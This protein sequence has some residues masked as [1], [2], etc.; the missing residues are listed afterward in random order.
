MKSPNS[1]DLVFK[2]LKRRKKKALIAY[3]AGGYP[4]WNFQR[5]LIKALDESGVDILE[6]GVPFSDPIADG[7]TIQFA[8][9]K[10]LSY[11]TTLQRI[12]AWAKSIRN[13]VKMPF[14]IMSYMNPILN[15]GLK[16]FA[17]DAADSGISGVIVPDLIPEEGEDIKKSLESEG[18]YLIFLVAPTTPKSRQK[19]IAHKTK[20]FLYAVS[21][22]GVTGARKKLPLETKIWLKNLSRLTTKPVCVGFGISGPKQ[23]KML[24][25]SVDGFI[26]GSA[27]IDVIRQS[28]GRY[29]K[30]KLVRLVKTLAKECSYGR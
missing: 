27:F 5:N 21:V 2:A 18:L 10:S 3:L 13:E 4:R 28:E 25:N 30:V 8:S 11:G 19:D 23:I 22:R 15:Y 6:L 1:I 16:K 29:T 17:K 9:Q 26:I 7:P 12:L 20:G 24:R 14:V